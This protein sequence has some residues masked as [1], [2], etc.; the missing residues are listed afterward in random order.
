MKNVIAH[1]VQL[2]VLRNYLVLFAIDVDDADLC[3]ETA[4]VQGDRGFFHRNGDR[5]GRFFVAV[6]Y[7]R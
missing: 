6:D 7:G 2:I 3:S 5:Q 1:R 4:L